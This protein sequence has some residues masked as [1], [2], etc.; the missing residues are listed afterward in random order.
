MNFPFP[1]PTAMCLLPGPWHDSQ[2]EPP[3]IFAVSTCKR[4][5]GLAGKTRVY[6]AWQST[7][8][9]L[10][11]KLAP[12]ISGGGAMFRSTVEQEISRKETRAMQL[13]HKSHARLQRLRCGERTPHIAP[14]S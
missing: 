3:G 11:T 7:H 13:P 6:L 12:G 2:P 8:A 10:P 9:V 5:W 1:P 4:A 14:L